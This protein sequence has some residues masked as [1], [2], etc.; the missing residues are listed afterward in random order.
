MADDATVWTSVHTEL[1]IAACELVQ[2]AIFVVLNVVYE[3]LETIVSVHQPR[4]T[5]A[6]TDSIYEVLFTVCTGA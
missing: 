1:L 3:L 5:H 2:A 6:V 4:S